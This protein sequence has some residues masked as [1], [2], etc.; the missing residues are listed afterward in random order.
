M[1]KAGRLLSSDTWAVLFFILLALALACL[2]V[3]LLSASQGLRK[4]GFFVALPL[5]L[6]SLVCLTFSA[7]QRAAYRNSDAAIV[8]RPVAPVKSSPGS[9][10]AKDLFL[11]HEGTRVRVTDRVGEWENVV[12]SDGRQGWISASDADLI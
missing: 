4:T 8:T 3:F 6:L 12:L 2:L 5:L 7:R 1:R 10:G 11:L 9:E